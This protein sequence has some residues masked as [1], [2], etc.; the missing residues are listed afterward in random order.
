MARLNWG[1]VAERFFETG[2]DRGVLYTGD[3]IGVPWNGLTSVSEAP[4]GGDPKPAYIDGRKFRNIASSEEFEATI[5]AFA[6][7]KEFG[8]CD[9]S[10]SIQNGLIATQQPRQAFSFS[11]RTLIGNPVEGTEL[12][13]KIHLVY[14]ALAGPASR[15]N[16]TIGDSTE[17]SKLSWTVTTLPPSLTGYKPTA[18]FVIDSTQTPLGLLT[19][20]EE[21]LYGNDVNSAR[22]PL[23]SELVAMFQSNGPLVHKNLHLNPAWRTT[24]GLVEVRRNVFRNP[25]CSV[26]ATDWAFA[27]GTTG[28]AVT[29]GRV[30]PDGTFVVNGQNLAYFRATWTNAGNGALASS[31]PVFGSPNADSI[32]VT[33]GAKYQIAGYT[34]CSRPD[35]TAVMTVTTHDAAGGS[36]TVV[37]TSAAVAIGGSA[38]VRIPGEF[39]VPAGA[40]RAYVRFYAS[41]GGLWQVGDTFDAGAVLVEAADVLFPYFDGDTPSFDGLTASWSSTVGASAP[42]LKGATFTQSPF[43][44][45]G[46]SP[47]VG[48]QVSPGIYR[49]LCKRSIGSSGLYA[50]TQ[51]TSVAAAPGDYFAGR[52][53]ARQVGGTVDIPLSPALAAYTS[54]PAIVNIISGGSTIETLLTPDGGWSDIELFSGAAAGA[55]AASLRWLIYHDS[56]ASPA[57]AGTVLEFTEALVEKVSGPGIGPAPYFDGSTEDDF[58]VNYAWDGPA[59]NSSSSMY[60]WN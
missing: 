59:D 48:W 5:E 18:H 37:F 60:D 4:T 21:I 47:V 54:V 55:S 51:V 33:A 24:N 36:Q 13:Y 19:A 28:G 35:R 34:R 49:I 39:T 32:L 9:G 22:M 43:L 14:N 56:G 17:A 40:T 16:G 41:G 25:T 53:K 3:G 8:P 42:V 52:V 2:V 38:I 29:T 1:V 11:Y 26:N 30:A 10:R 20:I 7:P 44:Y 6:A 57:P 58:G 31:G 27:I 45:Y 12:G 46:S 50:F 23:V 15:S